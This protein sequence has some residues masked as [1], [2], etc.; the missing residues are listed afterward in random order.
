MKGVQ[1][2]NRLLCCYCLRCY[3]QTKWKWAVQQFIIYIM[4]CVL[5]T[6]GSFEKFTFFNHFIIVMNNVRHS[7]DRFFKLVH[8]EYILNTAL[9]FYNISFLKERKKEMHFSKYIYRVFS[10]SFCDSLNCRVENPGVLV[11]AGSGSSVIKM[12]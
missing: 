5:R 3:H 8:K 7:K 11:G 12:I 9:K 4:D 10:T 2:N 6:E 1:F